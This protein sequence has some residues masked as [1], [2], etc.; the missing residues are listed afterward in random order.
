MFWH[1][2]DHAPTTG[3]S[4]IFL[5]ERYDRYDGPK[6]YK[7]KKATITRLKKEKEGSLFICVHMRFKNEQYFQIEIR[8]S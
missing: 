1:G 5:P 2:V 4:C 8:K 7:N 6:K 3:K